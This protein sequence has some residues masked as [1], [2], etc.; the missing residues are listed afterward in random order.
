MLSAMIRSSS[1]CFTF[2]LEL[3]QKIICS[4]AVPVND[5][6]IHS[7]MVHSSPIIDVAAAVI[8]RPDGS[9]LLARRPEGKPYAGYWEFPGGKVE[10]G[11]SLPHALSRELLEELGIQVEHAY[12][13]I[14]RVF[15]YPHATVRLRFYRVVKWHGEPHPHENQELSWQF[16][17]NIMVDPMLPAN[18]PVLRALGLPPVYAITNA[19]ELGVQFALMQIESALQRGLRLVQVREKGMARDELRAFAGEVVALAHHHGA[20]VLVNGDVA[21]SREIGADG[22]HFPSAQ[23]LD[24]SSR[25]DINWCGASCHNVEELFHAEQLAMDFVVLG[26]VLPTLSHSGFP[27]LGWQKFATLIRD[28]PLPVYALGGLRQEDLIT[29]WEHGGHGVAMMRS[30]AGGSFDRINTVPIE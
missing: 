25:P 1:P 20:R 22:V 21:L 26:P 5:P 23:L 30:M 28:Y 7:T 8:I 2:E 3:E 17:S 9:F 29:A 15:T 16:M 27:V 6:F 14:T 24:L 19:V 11:E 18:A 13:W 10:P 12:P 4:P